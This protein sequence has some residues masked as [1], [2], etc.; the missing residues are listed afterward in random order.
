MQMKVQLDHGAFMP[1]RAHPTDA[2]ADLRTP[3]DFTIM[4]F[5]GYTVD[6]GV[7][8]QLPE[9]TKCDVRSKSGLN[10]KHDIIT[11]GLVDEGF[12]G[13][14]KVRLLNL[15]DR[16]YGFRRGDKITQIVVTDVHYPDFVEVDRVSG[17]ERGTG[18]YGSTGR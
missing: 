9:G 12:T 2:G 17:G 16:P 7:H 1:E 14:I 10:I 4:P 8:I 6:T 15:S 5:G 3:I 11:V 13:S 18:G